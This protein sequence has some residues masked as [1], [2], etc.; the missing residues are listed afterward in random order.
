MDKIPPVPSVDVDGIVNEIK[1]AMDSGE[2]TVNKTFEDIITVFDI[3]LRIQENTMKAQQYIINHL[4]SEQCDCDLQLS[5]I[6]SSHD[7]HN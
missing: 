4:K 6:L 3:I 7:S 2:V 5:K 1:K